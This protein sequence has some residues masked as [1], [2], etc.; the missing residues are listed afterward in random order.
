MKK[1]EFKVV[2][3]GVSGVGKSSIIE[4]LTKNVFNHAQAATYGL[5]FLKHNI[6][7]ENTT[8]QLNSNW[9]MEFFFAKI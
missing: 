3:L 8:I 7:V 9:T 1:K 6:T 4:R 5:A 2:M